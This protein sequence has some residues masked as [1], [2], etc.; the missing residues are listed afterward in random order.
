MSR[1]VK[2]LPAPVNRLIGRDAEVDSVSRLA[3]D[4]QM[5][6]VIG[7]GGVLQ[8]VLRPSQGR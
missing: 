4:N 6:T 1:A 5:V 3:A 7:P 8:D 2:P